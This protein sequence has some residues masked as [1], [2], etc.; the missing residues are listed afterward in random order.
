MSFRNE[1]HGPRP[2]HRPGIAARVL[3]NTEYSDVVPQM[4][5]RFSL[6]P[7]KQTLATDSGMRTLPSREPSLAWQR[8]PSPADSQRLP[9]TS[10]RKPS[11]T[12]TGQIAN[13]SPPDRDLPSDDTLNH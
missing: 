9:C 8:T 12:P 13:T 3:R 10:T 1:A 7:P 6:G 2:V 5:R 4:N 11:N